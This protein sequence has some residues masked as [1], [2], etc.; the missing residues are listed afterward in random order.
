MLPSCICLVFFHHRP[1]PADGNWSGHGEKQGSSVLDDID[2]FVLSSS[3]PHSP[4]FAGLRQ[5]RHCSKRIKSARGSFPRPTLAPAFGSS[6]RVQTAEET[7]RLRSMYGSVA[8]PLSRRDDDDGIA[9]SWCQ[10][11]WM[12]SGS[13][14]CSQQLHLILCAA[15]IDGAPRCYKSGENNEV[16]SI[17]VST[18]M[19]TAMRHVIALNFVI[20]SSSH[21]VFLG[22]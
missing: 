7:R 14:E 1:G 12:V 18:T 11:N 13:M 8:N 6:G 9:S 2:R 21:G 10:G 17:V 16:S 15:A 5:W 22:L 20:C 19:G 4:S 3:S